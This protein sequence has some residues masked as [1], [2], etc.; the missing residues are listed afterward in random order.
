MSINLV[1]RDCDQ[2][3]QGTSRWI[4]NSSSHHSALQ[5][6]YRKN[7]SS[8]ETRWNF[9]AQTVSRKAFAGQQSTKRELQPT[10]VTLLK[11]AV[12]IPSK[13]FETCR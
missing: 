4:F 5:T 12:L 8:H 11:I 6:K 1:Q 10:A 3:T 7:G 13:E 2:I 9:P